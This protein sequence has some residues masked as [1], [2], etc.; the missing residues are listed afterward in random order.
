MS[1]A[2]LLGALFPAGH[3]VREEGGLLSGTGRAAGTDVAVVGTAAG[4]GVGVESALALA[5]DVLRVVRRHPGRPLLA[6]LD[7]RG[8][9]MSRRDE[10]LGLNGYLAHLAEAVEVARR[11]GHRVIALVYGEASS[12]S[13]LA[14]AFAADEVHAVPGARLSVM[15]LPAMARVTK[16][17]LE[18]LEEASR[19]SPILAPGLE[20]Y[21]RL[22]AVE[23]VWQPPLEEALARALARAPGPDGRARRGEERG[24]R[25]L[26]RPVAE[27]VGGGPVR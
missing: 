11:R 3:T 13:A 4:H 25:L 26:A 22:G 12:G 8:Q 14:L 27:R 9:R 21:V 16:I 15:N 1:A 5:G 7:S 19:S 17:P 2:E 6:L 18:R 10:V 20:N 24:G 23:S